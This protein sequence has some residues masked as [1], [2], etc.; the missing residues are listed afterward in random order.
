MVLYRAVQLRVLARA[1]TKGFSAPGPPGPTASGVCH[2]TAYTAGRD[3]APSLN[4]DEHVHP[5]VTKASDEAI[6][7]FTPRWLEE[8]RDES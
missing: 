8:A 5:P 3:G 4:H 7:L 2:I 6:K 1:S